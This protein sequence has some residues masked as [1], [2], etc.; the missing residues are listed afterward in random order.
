[1]IRRPVLVLLLLLLLLNSTNITLANQ[2]RN[3]PPPIFAG[4]LKDGLPQYVCAADAFASYYVLEQIQASGLDVKYKFHLGIVPFLLDGSGGKYDVDE[5]Q[6]GKLIANGDWDCLLTTLDS[7]AL[8]GSGA[9]TAV[10]DES[11]GADQIWARGSIKTLNDLKGKRIAYAQGS[12]GQ[13]MVLYALAVAGLKPNRDVQPV[14]ADSVESAIQAFKDQKADAV[15]GW[16]PDILAAAQAGGQKLIASDKLRVAVDVIVTSRG[17]IANRSDVAQAF[18]N[19]WFDALRAQFDSPDQ[20]AAAIVKWGHSDWSGIKPGTAAQDLKQ[21]LTSIAQATLAQ[22]AAIMG[23]P[24]ALVLRLEAAR[25]VWSI[26]DVKASAVKASTLVEPKFVLAAAKDP[27][28]T[29]KGKPVNDTF[30]MGSRPKIDTG[31]TGAGQTLAVLPCR[32]FDFLP[33]SAI[34]TGES[35]RILELCV[36]PV[37]QSTAGTYLKIVG[38]A[39]WPGPVGTFTQQEIQDFALARAVSVRDYLASKGIDA[40]RFVIEAVVPPS[41]RQN[42]EDEDVQAQDRYVE[43]TLL[44]TGR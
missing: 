29:P 31:D 40:S 20:A 5:E 36:V 43:L 16:E 14:E 30:L 7:V 44:E 13:F 9:I 21:G 10:I 42:S 23:D 3:G 34:L 28:L 41:D 11:A 27:S 4:D 15:S 18:H 39:A 32:R 24:A 33:D 25:R 1:M 8:N 17:A 26:A 35:R 38:S 6:R 12:V 37:M 22:N 19:A 2:T